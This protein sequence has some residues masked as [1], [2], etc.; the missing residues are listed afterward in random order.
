[1]NRRSIPALSAASIVEPQQH[2]EF[3]G[4]TGFIVR[5]GDIEALAAA[6]LKLLRDWALAEQLGR[7]ARKRVEEKFDARL[8]TRQYERLFKEY[9]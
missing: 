9:A 3:D 6:I 1:V 7:N 2:S 5:P 8:I 4:V